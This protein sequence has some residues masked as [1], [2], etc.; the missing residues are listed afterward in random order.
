M[1]LFKPPVFNNCTFYIFER[2][3]YIQDFHELQES[4]LGPEGKRLFVYFYF[5]FKVW[6]G[7]QYGNILTADEVY[8]G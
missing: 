1:L 4:R 5:P 8:V 2:L 3:G 7:G 6:F